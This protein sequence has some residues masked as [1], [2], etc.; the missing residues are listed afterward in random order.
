MAQEDEDNEELDGE[1]DN[2]QYLHAIQGCVTEML[3]RFGTYC[4]DEE[5]QLMAD[6]PENLLPAVRGPGDAHLNEI[7][8]KSGCRLWV[9]NGRVVVNGPCIGAHH[10]HSLLM[11][12]SHEVD[13]QRR[14]EDQS[15]GDS[16]A[17]LARL[18]RELAEAR[19]QN[20]QRFTGHG[21]DDGHFEEEAMDM[22]E[23]TEEMEDEE[24]DTT[25]TK[26]KKGQRGGWK[27]RL[28]KEK[29]AERSNEAS[30][31]GKGGRS[32]SSGKGGKGNKGRW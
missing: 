21:D 7:G 3:E 31:A 10:G 19:E 1:E 23:E 15:A 22:H 11:A 13:R 12:R 25:V 5:M 29:A 14:A 4:I 26:R 32:K 24:V 16:S 28:K 30:N 20:E 27:A 18:Q 2:M 8:R 17:E 6:V 9:D